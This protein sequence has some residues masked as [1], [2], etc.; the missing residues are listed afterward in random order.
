M[1]KK[2]TEIKK[3]MDER[4]WTERNPANLAKSIVIEGAELLEHFQWSHPAKETVIKDKKLLKEVSHELADIVIYC[5]DLAV[6][7]DLDLE[8][9]VD[10]K[11]KIVA[12]KYPVKKVKGNNA[13][14]Y[15]IKKAYRAKSNG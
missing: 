5:F 2:Q 14:Y 12:K 11:F 6:A 4:G 13:E 10:E 7:L 9:V 8:K 1:W 3:F 15:R